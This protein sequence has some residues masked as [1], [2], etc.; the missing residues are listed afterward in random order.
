MTRVR[1]AIVIP[2]KRGK[3]RLRQ[4]SASVS[5]HDELVRAIQSDTI[6]AALAVASAAQV[7]VVADAAS[8]NDVR[9]LTTDPRLLVLDDPGLGLNTALEWAQTQLSGAE[10]L[11]YAVVALVADLPSLRP[12]DL[13]EVLTSAATYERSFVA[14]HAGSGTVLLAAGPGQLLA[15]MFGT[16]SAARHVASGAVALA[17]ADSV[18]CDADN[19]EDLQRCLA[20]GVGSHTAVELARRFHSQPGMMGP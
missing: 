9:A 19:V 6:I 1:W 20:L 5:A 7:V 4:A 3:S 13:A 8:A 2:V 14:D 16:D 10:C 15:P 12:D 11:E 18:R 17:A